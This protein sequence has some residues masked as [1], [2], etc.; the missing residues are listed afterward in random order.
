[1][2]VLRKNLP[3][4][5]ILTSFLIA[6]KLSL[7]KFTFILLNL[8]HQKGLLSFPDLNCLKKVGPL[9]SNLIKIDRIGKSQ[10]N[11]KTIINKEKKISNTRFIIRLSIF[12]NGSGLNEITGI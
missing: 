5:V 12:S 11:K 3:S 7:S 1:M 8:K 10:L 9:D 4:F 6:C 2:L